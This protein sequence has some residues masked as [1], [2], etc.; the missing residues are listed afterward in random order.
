MANRSST[1]EGFT[2][3]D[4]VGLASVVAVLLLVGLGVS[5][6]NARLARG[7]ERRTR[8]KATVMSTEE[9]LDIY[10]E[11]IVVDPVADEP[12]TKT[13]TYIGPGLD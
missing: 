7:R 9:P 1:I 11:E 2:V 13:S 4:G 5:F 10:E 12:R 6:L 8:A 3:S